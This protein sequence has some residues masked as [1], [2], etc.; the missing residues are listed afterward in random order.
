MKKFARFLFIFMIIFSLFSCQNP[1]ISGMIEE[2]NEIFD[3]EENPSV[4]N[5]NTL[6]KIDY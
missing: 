6:F 1:S 4:S 5:Q 3:I 2:Y